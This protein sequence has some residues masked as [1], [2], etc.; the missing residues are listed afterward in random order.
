MPSAPS[1]TE[2]QN[3]ALR[4]TMDWLQQADGIDADKAK[5]FS[6][7]AKNAA[8]IATNCETILKIRN[9]GGR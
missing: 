1:V 6:L 5:D 3:A 7:A 2:L 9:G 4:R 8:A